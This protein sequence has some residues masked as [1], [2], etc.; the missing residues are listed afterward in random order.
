ME[1]FCCY[2]TR[3]SPAFSIFGENMFALNAIT[4]Q[5]LNDVSEIL[6]SLLCN[7]LLRP[8][9]GQVSGSESE[10]TKGHKSLLI[11]LPGIN[12]LLTKL[13][14]SAWSFDS[15]LPPILCNNLI[16]AAAQDGKRPATFSYL[17]HLPAC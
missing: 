14:Q 13:W 2:L 4:R 15:M 5:Y 1:P 11:G 16:W 9:E 12:L 8:P 10:S 3:N 7:S 17:T 6:V